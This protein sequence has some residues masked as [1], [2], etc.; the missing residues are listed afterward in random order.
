LKGVTP[1]VVLPDEYEYLKFREKDNE[2]A[3]PWDEIAKTN[4]TK[5]PASYDLNA[6]KTRSEQRIKSNTNFNLINNNALWLSKQNDKTYSLNLNKYKEEQKSIRTTVKQNDSLAKL[7]VQLP[8][9]GLKADAA[10]YNNVD[11]D[12]G[13]RYKSWLKN[14]KSDI[15]INEAANVLEDMSTKQNNVAAH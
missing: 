13:E 1:D 12:K 11:K 4:Y 5:W 8:V 15:Y 2:N 6:I 14:L 10:K 9:E 7:T 3:M